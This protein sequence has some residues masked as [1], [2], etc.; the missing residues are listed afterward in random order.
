DDL[1]PLRLP[2]TEL[3][4]SRGDGQ[5]LGVV[6]GAPGIARLPQRDP[7]HREQQ[8]GQQRERNQKRRKESSHVH[9]GTIV[10]R[11]P[12]RSCK[13]AAALPSA[14]ESSMQPFEPAIMNGPSPLY[15]ADIRSIVTF[16]ARAANGA[17]PIR[18]RSMSVIALPNRSMVT[19]V[20][21]AWRLSYDGGSSSRRTRS[22]IRGPSWSTDSP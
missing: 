13:S 21:L 1:I 2:K 5:R 18:S 14:T 11:S 20:P 4:P 15:V 3:R 7:R 19:I 8:R 10:T 9:A 16:P 12:R 22:S 6:P 17:N